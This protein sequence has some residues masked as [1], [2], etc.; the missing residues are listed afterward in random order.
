M[1]A[2]PIHRTIAN[3]RTAVNGDFISTA[4]VVD[5]LLDLR[6]LA[7]ADR[8]LVDEIDA[9]LSSI[10]G[11]SVAPNEWWIDALQAIE[12]LAGTVDPSPMPA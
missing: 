9:R 5:L 10:P 7:G 12:L 4:R 2:S 6:N 8:A 3:A 11:R 1:N